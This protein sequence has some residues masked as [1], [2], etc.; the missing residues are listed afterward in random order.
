MTLEEFLNQTN[1]EEYD[2][3]REMRSYYEKNSDNVQKKMKMSESDFKLFLD[4]MPYANNID[5]SGVKQW[6]SYKTSDEI[7]TGKRFDCDNSNLTCELSEKIYQSL[8]GWHSGR[9]TF[10]RATWFDCCL[11]GGDTINSFA[12]TYKQNK[13]SDETNTENEDELNQYAKEVGW[14]GNFTLI[15]ARCNGKRGISPDIKD[16]WDLT[17]FALSKNYMP[18]IV[19]FT[20]QQFTQYVNIFFLWDYMKSAKEPAPLFDR[21]MSLLSGEK[22]GASTGLVLPK[23]KKE[24]NDFLTKTNRLI[25]RRGTFMVAMLRIATKYKDDYK[26]IMEYLCKPETMISNCENA[27]E[28]LSGML[29]L[30]DAAKKLISETKKKIEIS[31]KQ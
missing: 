28:Q 22:W 5:I 30:S 31:Q 25:R 14:I 17:L 11:L 13:L 18:D 15:P 24:I 29:E 3:K 10:R 26:K 4:K 7:W 12:T 23:G 27:C 21:H 6:I 9:N 8:W 2:F 16:Y 20:E 19:T 1:P